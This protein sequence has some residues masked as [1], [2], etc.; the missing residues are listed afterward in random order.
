[1]AYS[2]R[3]RIILFGC[4][5]AARKVLHELE[6]HCEIIGFSDG[7]KNLHHKDFF[8][9]QVHPPTDLPSLDFDKVLIASVFHQEITK[10][11]VEEVGLPVDRI[12]LASEVLSSKV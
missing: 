3:K 8:G 2:R 10:Q 12:G 9:L 11:L 1:M 5:S 4:G 7:N 6:Q